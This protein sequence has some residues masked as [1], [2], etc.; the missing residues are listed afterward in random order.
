MSI[1]VC[2][3]SYMCSRSL[4]HLSPQREDLGVDLTGMYGFVSNAKYD[5]EHMSL[6]MHMAKT[7]LASFFFEYKFY[8]FN[9]L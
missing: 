5:D 7:P 8:R 2:V 4:E 6:T 9:L 1:R 3:F